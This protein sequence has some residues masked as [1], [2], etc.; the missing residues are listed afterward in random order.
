[1]Q[2]FRN[3]SIKLKLTLIITL[4]SLVAVL[5]SCG[6]FIIYDQVVSR[7]AM[8]RDLT[9]VAEMIGS[10]STAAL[11]FSDQNS[12]TETLSALSAESHI[13]SACIY[14][15][16]GEPFAKYVRNTGQ[17]NP[18][19]D[20]PGRDGSQL[21]DGRL[22]L[23]HMI[24]LDDDVA[25]TVYLESDMQELHARLRRYLEILG[26][27]MLGSLG[28][29]LLIS[30]AIQRVISRPI[31]DLAET[32]KAVSANKNYAVRASKHSDDEVGLLIDCF[33]EMLAQIQLRD[34]ELGR[35]R[36]HLEDEVA[37]RT[38]E[39]RTVNT[40]L[41]AA[42]EKAEEGNKAKSEFLANMSHE[43]RT[44]MNGIMGMTELTLDTELTQEQQEYVGM[45]KLSA[46]SL[47]TVI[48]DILDFSKIEAGKLDL[49]PVPFN[50]RDNMDEI[51]KTFALR[52]HEKGLELAFR[53]EPDVPE[54]VVGDPGRLRQI[55]INL[56]GNAIKFTSRGE[57]V[58]NVEAESIDPREALIRF[59]V[60]DTGIGIPL[61]K[62]RD[63]FAAFTQADG[64]T[65]RRYGGTGLGLTISNHLVDMMGGKLQVESQEGKGSTFLF[66]AHFSM[67]GAETE[68]PVK[69][70]V[71][72]LRDMRTLVVDDNATNRRI[73]EGVLLGWHMKPSLVEDGAS[74]YAEIQR[75]SATGQP[76]RLVLIDGQMPGM[77]GFTLVELI[78]HTPT[79]AHLVIMMLTSSEQSGDSSRCRGLGVGACLT[80]PIRQSELLTAILNLLGATIPDQ[81]IVPA[82][83]EVNTPQRVIQQPTTKLRIL[84]A[85]DNV[86]NQKLALGMLTKRGHSVIVASNGSQALSL[87]AEQRSHK[88]QPYDLILMDV[89]MPIMDGFEATAAIRAGEQMTG[90]HIPIIA[91]TAHAMKGD[92]E[93]CLEAGME[94]YVSKPIHAKTLFETIESLGAS[95]A[96][97]GAFELPAPG[98]H[99][100][101]DL[102]AASRLID[103]DPELLAEIAGLFV[104]QYPRLLADLNGALVRGDGQALESTAHSLRGAVANFGARAAVEAAERIESL[105]RAGDFSEAREALVLL[106]D[107][108]ERI[109]PMLTEAANQYPALVS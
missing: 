100:K 104:A 10:N 55:I 17:P 91:M 84:L 94:G 64:S 90:G 82:P 20:Q 59:A 76:Y 12:A 9:A 88:E 79:L 80:K 72:S 25:G 29:A 18:I 99:E 85:E 33:N 60:T 8:V 49:D 95:T 24:V 19:P 63:V 61:K 13:V 70:D 74:A 31:V 75:A 32:A 78:K 86:V 39:I 106:H 14:T 42:K 105:G 41:T 62:Q 51:M 11:T 23:F 6:S 16:E 92:R 34:E 107:E 37:A 30:S 93:R 56:V 3:L 38:A 102:A 2:A 58:V 26:L 103:A 44:P 27:I 68:R 65:S 97:P 35:H 50:L 87:L 47:L 57:V 109:R 4:I 21:K 52:A 66:T 15:R 36:E 1:M 48:N 67:V 46:D 43:I 83:V 71:S 77:D 40:E 54:C 69:A 98:S 7:R 53:M 28:I 5:L 81:S 101:F 96:G 45:I 22:T 89:Q 73:L 108:L